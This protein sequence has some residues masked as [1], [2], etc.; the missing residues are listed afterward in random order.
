MFNGTAMTAA[1]S[2]PLPEL[3]QRVL[4]LQV[5]TLV[6]MAVEAAIAL[7]TAWSSRSPALF[8]FG[9]DSLIELLS[10]AVVYWRFR[11]ALNEARAAR[12]AGALLFA[13]AALVV[14]ACVLNFLGNYEAT[15]SLVGIVLLA[16][17]AVV[18]PWLARRKRQLADVTSSVALKA[19]AA[20]SGL[21]GYMAWIALAGLGVNAI[22]GK[23]W[24]D[25]L[26]S[27][28]L[29]PLILREGWE[30]IRNARLGCSCAQ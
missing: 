24:A 15:P 30:A 23:S 27:L 20:Q 18:M 4:Q 1:K 8:A 26:A 6:W 21:C 7:G 3:S 12:I 13:L 25:P 14:I 5:V 2:A 19:D 9:G 17:A 11:F 10:A 16:A 22:W 29:T 28:I